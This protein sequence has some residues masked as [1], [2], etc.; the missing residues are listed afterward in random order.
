MELLQRVLDV[1][2]LPD[3]LRPPVGVLALPTSL[4]GTGRSTVEVESELNRLDEAIRNEK[5]Q[6]LRLAMKEEQRHLEEE[7]D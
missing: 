6:L 7:E 4:S 1:E 5:R 2:R 3:D